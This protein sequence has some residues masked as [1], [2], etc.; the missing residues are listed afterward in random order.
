MK[1]SKKIKENKLFFVIFGLMMLSS[2]VY[3]FDK[4]F[5]GIISDEYYPLYVVNYDC[6]YSSRLFIGALFSLF[7]KERISITAITAVLLILY[8]I[9][10][11]FISLF[12]NSYL[13]ENKYS[14]SLGL[15]MTL[16]VISPT[17]L[18]LVSYL[19]TTDIF[20]LFLV[21]GSVF[22]AEKKYLRWLVPVFCVISLAIHEVF[23]I[24]Y[25]PLIVL[26]LL[27]RFFQK[28]D[29]SGLIFLIV[30]ILIIGAAAIYFAFIGD[31]TMKMTP[32]Q[33][34]DFATGRLDLEGTQFSDY[35][36]R[37]VFFWETPDLDGY[38]GFLG[39]L[40]YNMEKFVF[41]I[42]GTFYKIATHIISVLLTATPFFFLMVRCAKQEKNLGRKFIFICSLLLILPTLTI[43]FFSTDT[44]RYCLHFILNM[45]LFLS[46]LAKENDN[47]FT[48]SCNWLA[49]KIETNKIACAALTVMAIIIIV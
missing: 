27:Y 8:F 25:L 13:K 31:G 17:F 10:C 37:S 43:L 12:I 29:K 44:E 48:E 4:S 20:W 32:D 49:K 24:T 21:L 5:I 34:I 22:L 14:T 7:F 39:Y 28:S 18:A 11:F 30:S 6:G 35:Y 47:T 19:G 1:I 33:F 46:F 42:N 15:Y 38:S 41:G 3:L 23:C 36:A 26:I 2:A 9:I 16:M 40:K 45:I